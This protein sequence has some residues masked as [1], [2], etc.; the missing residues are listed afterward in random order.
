MSSMGLS[1]VNSYVISCK[2]ENARKDS[3]LRRVRLVNRSGGTV[4]KVVVPGEVSK[5]EIGSSA[6]A[7]MGV[8]FGANNKNDTIKLDAK[9]DRGSYV[10]EFKI[11]PTESIRP[12]ELSADQFTVHKKRLSGFNSCAVP[13]SFP[14]SV[15]DIESKMA[16]ILN[17]HV[18]ETDE[19]CCCSSITNAGD[20]VLLIVGGGEL[21][22]HSDD[23]VLATNLAEMVKRKLVASC[24]EDA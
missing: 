2:F 20:K 14:P 11:P 12:L 9:S 4:R 19:L 23:A 1:G 15:E 13:F 24:N 8:D 5:L 22:V 21:R 18:V 3:V 10:I 16:E 17:T 6:E 7:F